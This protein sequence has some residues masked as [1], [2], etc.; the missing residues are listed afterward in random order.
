MIIKSL[1]R[2]TRSKKLLI[3][4]AVLVGLISTFIVLEM[5]GVTH[6]FS[7]PDVQTNSE[8][9]SAQSNFTGGHEREVIYS[10]KNEGIV[11]DTQGN[12]STIPPESDWSSS[13]D[14]IISVYSPTK[15]SVLSSGQTLSGESTVDT[16]SFRLID[17]ISGV[18]A[19][20]KISVISG[21]FSGIFDFNTSATEGR[22][23]VFVTN[24][25]GVESS[26]VEVP[27]RF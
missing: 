9:P 19:Q 11:T 16:I 17:N 5:T 23:D 21:K 6:F 24:T 12:V 4:I 1:K 22:L 3:G 25:N 10:D 27:V 20:G 15:N 14:G 26:I 18:I 8:E 13:A 2:S 7:P